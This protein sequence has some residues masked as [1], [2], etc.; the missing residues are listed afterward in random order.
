MNIFQSQ[1]AVI[2]LFLAAAVLIALAIVLFR[3]SEM[4]NE[5]ACTLE[6][7]I[8]PDGSAVGRT[9]PSC[10]FAPCPMHESTDG[11]IETQDAESG[12]YYFYPKALPT[13]YSEALDW[14][15]VLRVNDGPFLCTEAGDAIDRTGKTSLQTMGE[16]AYCVTEITEGAAGSIYTQYAYAFPYKDRVAILTFSIKSVQ[17]GNFDPAQQQ[18]CEAERADLDLLAYVDQMAKSLHTEH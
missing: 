14:P 3:G 4:S 2:I 18:A 10:E 5:V 8:C 7:K 11:M 6:A 16:N 12:V 17:C 15:P 1:K 9:G 13:F